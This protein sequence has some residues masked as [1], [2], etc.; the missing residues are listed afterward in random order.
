MKFN[1]P[2]TRYVPTAQLKRECGGDVDFVYNHDLY[3][4][5]LCSLAEKRRMDYRARWEKA[6]EVIGEREEFLRGGDVQC[7]SGEFL[8]SE[9]PTGF[10]TESKE[11]KEVE[12]QDATEEKQDTTEEKQDATE[13][14]QEGKQA[15]QE[16][17]KGEV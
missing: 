17:E 15:E 16:A 4:P 14:K 3:W 9:F 6:G 2:L 10:A 12:K 7:L 11:D 8:G 1:E 5:A 13:E